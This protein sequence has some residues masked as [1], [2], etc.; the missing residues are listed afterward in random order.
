MS[1][2]N[3]IQTKVTGHVKIQ[4]KNTL[5]VLRDEF[6]AV[7]PKNMGI[8]IARGLSNEPKQCVY[9]IK[10]G[11]GGTYQGGTGEITYLPP[12]TVGAGPSTTTGSKLYN[13]TYTAVVDDLATGI[14]GV[15]NSVIHP[16]T[17]DNAG[18]VYSTVVISAVISS[19]AGLAGQALSDSPNN[20]GANL[21]D[22]NFNP[23]DPTATNLANQFVF[24]ELGL[25]TEDEY[26]L[27]H[28]IFSPIEKTANRELLITYTLTITVA[29]A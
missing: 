28:L 19:G 29:G 17:E 1:I 21:T 8:A 18:A 9:K 13:Y 24:D 2:T 4:D 15:G 11:N 26:M 16:A 25:F 12:N 22:P 14:V 27:T 5:E 20:T 10:M 7:H 6:N 3:F 23:I